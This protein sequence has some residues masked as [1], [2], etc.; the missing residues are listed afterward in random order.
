MA[1]LG[2]TVTKPGAGFGP[3]RLTCSSLWLSTVYTYR[4]RL[5]ES[6][7]THCNSKCNWQPQSVCDAILSMFILTRGQWQTV[8][9]KEKCFLCFKC[10]ENAITIDQLDRNFQFLYQYSISPSELWI[11]L[12]KIQSQIAINWV[13]I[14]IHEVNCV[15]TYIRKMVCVLKMPFPAHVEDRWIL[16][17]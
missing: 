8:H 2:V 15:P 1:G 7:I 5:G 17:V 10:I 13:L 16:K 11:V 3:K 9:L 4:K 6:N 12:W 14:Y